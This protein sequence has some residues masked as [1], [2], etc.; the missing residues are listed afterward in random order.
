MSVK[1]NKI[2]IVGWKTGD[3]S[4]GVTLA[5]LKYFS[6]LGDVVVLGVNDNIVEDLD[7][8]VLPGGKDV[9]PLRYG[10]KP[11]LWCGDQNLWLEHF[12]VNILPKYID[13]G[14]SIIGICRG[15]QT[16]NTHF[17]GTLEQ[18][19]YN[20]PTSKSDERYQLVHDVL[21][22]TADRNSGQYTTM[23]NH[24]EGTDVKFE[25]NSLHH[26]AF[27]KLGEELEVLARRSVRK[28]GK[29]YLYEIEAIRHKTLPI[30]AVQWHPEEI[31]DDFS[32]E[33]IK[34]LLNNQR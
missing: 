28:Q 19:L 16:I 13:N 33:L 14:T 9:N 23:L 32:A 17:K 3:N 26:Q 24:F 21:Q 7:L 1:K 27:D 10:Q 25:V 11:D 30:G 6:Y 8:L 15:L 29:D 5:Y 34:S 4:F 2:G 22:V 12:D 20:H 31:Y 18:H